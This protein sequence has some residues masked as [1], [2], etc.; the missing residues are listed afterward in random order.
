M[1]RYIRSLT[2]LRNV[3]LANL[4]D[5]VYTTRNLRLLAADANLWTSQTRCLARDSKKHI[6]TKLKA[7]TRVSKASATMPV[8][9][10]IE[11]IIKPVEV[12]PNPQSDEDIGV[13]LCGALDKSK[14]FY[15]KY[16]VLIT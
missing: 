14:R 9:K 4:A 6:V 15:Q 16:S 13:E 5:N 1:H 11:D 7:S 2:L 8:P 3:H 12:K 10:S